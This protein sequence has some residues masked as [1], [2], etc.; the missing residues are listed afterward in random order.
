[1]KIDWKQKLSSRK[2]WCAVAAALLSAAAVL[3]GEDIPGGC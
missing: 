1:M 2:L 3:M